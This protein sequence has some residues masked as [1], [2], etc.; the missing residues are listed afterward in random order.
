MDRHVV[1]AVPIIYAC[2]T[3]KQQMSGVWATR[4]NQRTRKKL[5]RQRRPLLRRKKFASR[6]IEGPIVD[7]RGKETQSHNVEYI[8]T[9][10][11]YNFRQWHDDSFIHQ[12]SPVWKISNIF[13]EFLTRN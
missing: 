3:Y 11:L 13:S 4:E 6:G 8:Y 1:L 9:R 5:E 12:C 7:L 10:L 2:Y